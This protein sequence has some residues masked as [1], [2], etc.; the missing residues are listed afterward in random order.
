[1]ITE[2]HLKEGEKFAFVT[3]TQELGHVMVHLSVN[4]NEGIF[5][6]K[7]W[8]METAEEDFV[9]LIEKT[10]MS[11]PMKNW[12]LAGLMFARGLKYCLNDGLTFLYELGLQMANRP[13]SKGPCFTMLADFIVKK[14]CGFGLSD[15]GVSVESV[16]GKDTYWV[17]SFT[18]ENGEQVSPEDMDDKIHIFLN[19]I[20]GED[21][22]KIVTELANIY[23]NTEKELCF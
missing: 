2:A 6:H 1:M 13:E 16:E 15:A 22:R 5:T 19:T 11:A 12:A 23:I 4:C 10:K 18:L 20:S 21:Q 8:G 14:V 17:D 3:Y 9:N 7:E